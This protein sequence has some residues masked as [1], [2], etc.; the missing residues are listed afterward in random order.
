MESE[1]SQSGEGPWFVSDVAW[2]FE[3]GNV[4]DVVMTNFDAPM[5]ADGVADG[6]GIQGDLA[7]TESDFAGLLPKPCLGVLAP[8][9]TDHVDGY[10]DQPLPVG[11]KASGCVESFDEA[12]NV[13]SRFGAAVS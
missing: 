10:L 3:E 2:I 1:G 9:M 7:C 4:A 11:S 6:L 13:Y 12:I 5:L 8:D